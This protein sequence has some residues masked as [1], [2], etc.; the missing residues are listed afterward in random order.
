MPAGGWLT[1]TSIA[2]P[3]TRAFRMFFPYVFES[4]E[5]LLEDFFAEADR[6]ILAAKE[7]I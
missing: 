7:R 2:P 6:V 1:T 4:P 5:K 3:A